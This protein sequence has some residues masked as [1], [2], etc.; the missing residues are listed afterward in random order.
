MEDLITLEE[1]KNDLLSCAIHLAGNINSNDGQAAALKPIVWQ[2]LEKDDVDNAA[3]YADQI[4]D[5][6]SR[7]QLLIG[8]IAKCVQ[9]NDDDYAFQLVEAIDDPGTQAAA[10]EAIALQKSAKGEF[11][12]A[13]EIT[14]TLEHSSDAYA[15]IAVNQFKK[16]LETDGLATLKKID[17]YKSIVDALQEIAIIFLK[18]EQSEKAVEYLN[19]GFDLVDEIEFTED[20]IRALLEIGNLYIEAKD[21]E[22]AV[23]TFAKASA[24]I[25]VLDGIH[26]DALFANLAVGFLK[27]EDID[28]ADKT[29]DEVTDKTQISSSLLG[30]SQIFEAAG[31]TEE[32]LDTIEESYAML[33]SQ[34]E[35][36]VRDSKARYQLFASIATQFARLGKIERAL[37]IAHENP[38]ELQKNLA[39]TN[40][41]QVCILQ[42]NDEMAEQALKGIE[43]DSQK[44]TALVS[45][46]DAKN[47]IERQDEAVEFL[48][49][50]ASMIELIPQFIERSKMQNEIAIRYGF[51]GKSDKARQIASGSL[52]TISQILGF[53][54]RSFALVELAKVY[55]KYEFELTDEDKEILETLVRKSDW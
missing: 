35:N 5:S 52:E 29:L 33:K 30:F 11:E 34:H 16:G 17:F 53:E 3:Q 27:A 23:E 39:L 25:E 48:D 49:E 9:L 7:N 54:N 2:Y 20:R 24:E 46:S 43:N 26:K 51:Y 1:A 18:Q 22:K 14:Q 41:G 6:F 12:K 21:N 32:S 13:L 47:K 19:N 40:I 38:V 36:E 8:V 37:E 10:R 50:A 45:M 28:L 44:L 31:E 15:G 42:G 55:D 4:N